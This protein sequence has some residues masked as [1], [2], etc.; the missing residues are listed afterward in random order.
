MTE[1]RSRGRLV[2]ERWRRASVVVALLSLSLL[3]SACQ[4][5]RP[6]LPFPTVPAQA[7][8]PVLNQPVSG[9]SAPA[10]AWHVALETDQ[11]TGS[12]IVFA[13]DGD[14]VLCFVSRFADGS[15]GGVT[16][17]SGG[18]RSPGRALTLDLSLGTPKAQVADLLSGRV[19]TGTI[20]VRVRTANGAEDLAVVANGYYL[21][22][23]T[24]PAV[25]VEIDALDATGHLLQRLADPIGPPIPS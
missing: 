23:L 16:T 6:R 3:V 22:W 4:A 14:T 21:A 1:A 19:P 7:C 8:Q 15:L 17:A 10:T 2:G 18:Q 12:A 9:G 13:S 11:P 20:T 5:F 25:P 24:V